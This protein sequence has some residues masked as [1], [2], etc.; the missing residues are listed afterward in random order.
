MKK[1]L[2][3][4]IENYDRGDYQSSTPSYIIQELRKEYQIESILLDEIIDIV[5]FDSIVNDSIKDHLREEGRMKE[6][7]RFCELL[8]DDYE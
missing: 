3:R 4:I 5:C 7:K 2:K 8:G 1:S 6:L